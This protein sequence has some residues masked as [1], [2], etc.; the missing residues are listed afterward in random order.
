MSLPN[1]FKRIRL[2][3]AREPG[4]PEGDSSIGYQFTAP[5]DPDARIDAD[6]WRE[7]RKDC[8]VLRFRPK[9]DLD[10]GHLVRRGGGWAFHY[11]I[12]G[13][14]EDEAGFRFADHAFRL[15]EYVSIRD[16]D[17][18]RTFRVA[19]ITAAPG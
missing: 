16:G 7:H 9:G 10:I 8:T 1:T 3:L 12:D 17:D 4:H 19:S 6:L 11:D 18:M 14:E 5:L 13:D 15:G 2:E